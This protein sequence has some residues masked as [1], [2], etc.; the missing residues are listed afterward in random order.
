[1]LG[2]AL[3]LAA[4]ASEARGQQTMQISVCVEKGGVMST[5]QADL[6]T[7]TGDTTLNG[8]P[9]H[10]VYPTNAEYALPAVWYINNDSIGY[11]GHSY[12]RYGLPRVLGSDQVVKDGDGWYRGVPVF[13]AA[14]PGD[15]P[16][17]LF[18]PVDP[19]CTFIG[20]LKESDT[21]GVRG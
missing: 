15:A 8:R 16:G 10:D 21:H 17:M 9:L 5:L 6:N 18:L 3:V 13:V 20:Y 11:A 2:A 12:G 1:M 7:A 14:T 19:W 4:A